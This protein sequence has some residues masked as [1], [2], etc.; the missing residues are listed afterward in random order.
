M[1]FLSDGDARLKDFFMKH[2]YFTSVIPSIVVTLNEMKRVQR[3][4]SRAKGTLDAFG[5]ILSSS[6]SLRSKF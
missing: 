5:I 3:L 1:L 2:Q 4:N 6:N